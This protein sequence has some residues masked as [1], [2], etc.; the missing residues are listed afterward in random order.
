MRRFAKNQLHLLLYMIIHAI[1]SV[2]IRLRQAWRAI[3]DRVYAILYYHHRTPELIQ[4]DVR[5][6][7]RLPQ[8][9]SVIL[10]LDG[11]TKGGAA[12]EALVDEAA[13][14]A[15]WCACAGITVLSIYEKTGKSQPS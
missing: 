6:L 9:L 10:K 11:G 5:D 15:A 12:L 8:H 3:K 7:P 13:E 2:Y 1:F 4:K 14:I